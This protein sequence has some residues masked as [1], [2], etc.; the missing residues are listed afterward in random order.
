MRE[1]QFCVQE[2]IVKKSFLI[3]LSLVLS[4]TLVGRAQD[5]PDAP[6]P[7]VIKKIVMGPGYIMITGRSRLDKAERLSLVLER[8]PAA[9]FDLGATEAGLT[10]PGHR[11]T[12]PGKYQGMT[13]SICEADPLLTG[14]GPCNKVGVAGSSVVFEELLSWA[15]VAIPRRLVH[16]GK[17]AKVTTITVNAGVT[18]VHIWLGARNIRLMQ[19]FP[20][21][22]N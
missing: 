10:V 18:A 11:Y 2:T 14:F 17:T 4:S 6:S 22:N 8:Y 9:V 20:P 15:S 16:H 12:T 7:M 1:A 21:K 5:L 3:V 13:V 19:D